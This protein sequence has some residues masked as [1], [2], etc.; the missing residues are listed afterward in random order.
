[1]EVIEWS[2]GNPQY[3]KPI[4]CRIEREIFFFFFWLK[5]FIVEFHFHTADDSIK[6]HLHEPLQQTVS[7]VTILSSTYLSIFSHFIHKKNTTKIKSFCFV[8]L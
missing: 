4:L 1:M 3:I 5:L 8:Q 2:A 7:N 6:L